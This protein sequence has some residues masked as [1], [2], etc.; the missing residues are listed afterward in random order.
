MSHSEP[1]EGAN[2]S[3]CW[4]DIT[5]ENYM[6][7]SPDGIFRLLLISKVQNGYHHQFVRCV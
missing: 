4:D 2:C 7:I 1:P 6:E 5:K 3:I